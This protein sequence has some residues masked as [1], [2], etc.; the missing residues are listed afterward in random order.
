MPANNDSDNLY[1]ALDLDGEGDIIIDDADI[2]FSDLE[3]KYHVAAPS[4][5]PK[6]VIVDGVPVIDASKEEKLFGVIKKIFKNMGEITENGMWMPKDANG[7][8][9]GCVLASLRCFLWWFY[10]CLPSVHLGIRARTWHRFVV[11]LS[12]RTAN[13]LHPN[14]RNTH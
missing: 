10:C 8:S 14:L 9:K 5:Y 11:V 13:A 6:V 4:G 1:A 3:A 7:K 12:K 2:D